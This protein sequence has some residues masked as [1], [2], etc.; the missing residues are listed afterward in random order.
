[1]A[2]ALPAKT[3]GR[4]IMFSSLRGWTTV[5]CLGTATSSLTEI[6]PG[7]IGEGHVAESGRRP[8]VAAST[9]DFPPRSP[10]RRQASSAERS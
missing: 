4:G 1:M 8:A 7:S 9:A 3:I 2:T 5:A 10:G 6:D